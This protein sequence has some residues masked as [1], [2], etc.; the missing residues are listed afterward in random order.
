MVLVEPERPLCIVCNKNPC[1]KH[2]YTK[3]GF[4]K[5]RTMCASCHSKLRNTQEYSDKRLKYMNVYF[6]TTYRI[7]KKSVCIKCG[8]IPEDACQ[9]DVDHIDGN[10]ANNDPNN[11]QTLCANC[12]RLK[13]KRER[14]EN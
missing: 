10:H 1:G 11:L 9:L 5:Y 12:H 6:S 4:S 14:L 2:G 3:L 7:Y 13:S 8:F